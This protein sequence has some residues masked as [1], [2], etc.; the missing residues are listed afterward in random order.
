MYHITHAYIAKQF[1][2]ANQ[3]PADRAKYVIVGSI[4]NDVMILE[5]NGDISFEDFEPYKM[6]AW[7]TKVQNKDLALGMLTHATADDVSHGG[8]IWGGSGYSY[9]MWW[10]T[11]WPNIKPK[12][13]KIQ[14]FLHTIPELDME[15]DVLQKH[16]ETMQILYTAIEQVDLNEI[17]KDLATALD[18][19]PK[20]VSQMFMSYAKFIP[21]VTKLARKFRWFTNKSKQEECLELCLQKCEEKMPLWKKILGLQ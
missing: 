20:I 4:I 18:R 13:R 8:Y 12:S 7:I 3:V 5:G 9:G 15:F 17:G 1:C 14:S 2:E 19:D 6:E 10:R 16:P 21:K 11:H